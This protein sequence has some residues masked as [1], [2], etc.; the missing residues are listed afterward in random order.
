M[1][2][3]ASW[4][5]LNIDEQDQYRKL[6]KDCIRASDMIRKKQWTFDLPQP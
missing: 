4:R 5:A 2:I 6:A 1:R 3:I